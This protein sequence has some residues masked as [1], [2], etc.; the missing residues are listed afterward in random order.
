M[1]QTP[2]YVFDTDEF[3]KRGCREIDSSKSGR[4]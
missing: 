1:R 2:Y 4:V 3:A